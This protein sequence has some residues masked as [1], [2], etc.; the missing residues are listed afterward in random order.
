MMS[1]MDWRFIWLSSY[2]RCRFIFILAPSGPIP[3]V[4]RTAPFSVVNRTDRAYRVDHQL[5]SQG[6]CTWMASADLLDRLQGIAQ[7]SQFRNRE[8][9]MLIPLRL[10]ILKF[11]E[12]PEDSRQLFLMSHS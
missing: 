6:V 5:S 3:S 10:V 11:P 1:C 9:Q 7:F 4:A 12:A 8:I 2:R